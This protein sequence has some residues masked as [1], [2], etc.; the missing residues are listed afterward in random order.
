MR[1]G[2][3]PA[4]FVGWD[5]NPS[6]AI[7]KSAGIVIPAYKSRRR[8]QGASYTGMLFA[9]AVVSVMLMKVGTMWGTQLRREREAELLFRGDEI[10]RALDSYSRSGPVT[11]VYP[12]TL[13]DLV[14]DRREI[15][16]HRYLRRVY[17]DPIT[18]KVDWVLV[19]D[20]NGGI[21]AVHSRATD[22][23]LKHAGFDE[24]DE[25][26]ANAA[27]YADWVFNARMMRQ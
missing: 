1:R 22:T 21:I 20:P 12:K 5:D 26:F 2:K 13:E 25:G 6:I 19:R 16:I 14:E 8:Q 27:S 7:S 9:V 15:T 4:A 23:P 3:R 10:R 17:A 24:Q 18:G 11:G